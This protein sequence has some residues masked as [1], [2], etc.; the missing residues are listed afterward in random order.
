MT[1]AGP[2]LLVQESAP[3]VLVMTIDRWARR[4]SV[5]TPLA[6]QLGDAFDRLE[7]DPSLRVGILTS[8]GGVFSA[9]TDLNEGHT[10]S[11][12]S[13]G[14]YGVVRRRRSTPVIAAVDGAALGGG[15][16]LVL[17]CDLVVASSAAYFQL[18]EVSRGVVATC[19]GLFRAADRLPVHIAHQMLLTGDPISAEQA[20]G[21]GFVNVLCEPGEVLAE[22]EQLA[23]RI[24]G[25]SPAAVAATLD[26]ISAAGVE[27]DDR[28]WA[29][30]EA[31]AAAAAAS[32]DQ[33]EGIAAFLERREPRWVV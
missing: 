27:R 3:G 21:W 24:I 20:A 18:P 30:T 5:D 31:A 28:G 32:R 13:G 12:E 8:R 23:A 6:G 17:A 25:N 2:V 22:A 10:P 19:G 26:A 14:E 4:N 9:G 29:V 1:D 16:E 7:N 15:F 33:A 11:T